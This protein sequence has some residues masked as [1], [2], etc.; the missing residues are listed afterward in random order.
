[1]EL[2]FDCLAGERPLPDLEQL[3]A[4]PQGMRQELLRLIRREM[5]KASRGERCGIACL[6]NALTDVELIDALTEASR[7]GVPVDRTVRG[8]CCLTAGV[9]GETDRITVRSVVGRF[10]EHGRAFAF[11]GE[12]EE[13]VFFSSA[14]WMKRSL[15]RRMELLVPVKDE[16]C[17]RKLL[18]CM[19]ARRT[20]G[21][22][23][24]LS[25]MDEYTAARWPEGET[26]H[27]VQQRLMERASSGWTEA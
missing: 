20:P 2:F 16:D 26:L 11:G 27:D 3:T 4:A 1:M 6:L 14:D 12:G 9:P 15:N 10:L 25:C 13:E 22:R 7:A 21:I 8:A 18:G 19:K 17:R 5:D 23:A 24:W